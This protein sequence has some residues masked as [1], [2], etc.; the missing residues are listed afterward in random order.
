MAKKTVDFN[1]SGVSQLPRD[2]PVVYKIKDDA[3]KTNY[4]G[5]AKRGRIQERIQEHLR[6]GNIPGAK[7]QIEQKTSIQ[8]ARKIEARVIARTKPAHNKQG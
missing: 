7:V 3:G 6:A 1:R 8:E 4:V 2:K 5:V